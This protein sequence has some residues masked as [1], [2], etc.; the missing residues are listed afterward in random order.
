MGTEFKCMASDSVNG[1]YANLGKNLW[2]LNFDAKLKY[3]ETHR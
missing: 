1:D 3:R 2:P